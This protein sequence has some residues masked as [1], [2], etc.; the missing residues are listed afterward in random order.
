MTIRFE[1][2]RKEKVPSVKLMVKIYC[3]KLSHLFEGGKEILCKHGR[4]GG[5]E[6]WADAEAAANPRYVGQPKKSYFV[7]DKER[8]VSLPRRLFLSLPSPESKKVWLSTFTFFN[9]SLRLGHGLGGK[10]C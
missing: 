2:E 4:G 8:I 3:S 9:L 10:F 1:N 6:I 5:F 7:W